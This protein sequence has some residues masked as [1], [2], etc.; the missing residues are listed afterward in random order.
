[1]VTTLHGKNLLLGEQ[2]LSFK[3]TVEE[4]GKNMM[5]ELLPLKMY[6]FTERTVFLYVELFAEEFL[7][8]L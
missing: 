3:T 8:P 1:M 6:P 7:A 2:T 5:T 4:G